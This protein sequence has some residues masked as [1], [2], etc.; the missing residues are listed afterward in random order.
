VLTKELSEL[1]VPRNMTESFMGLAN[2]ICNFSDEIAKYMCPLKL[3][4]K[5]RIKFDWLPKHQAVF[6]G[7]W[8]FLSSQKCWPSTIQ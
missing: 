4:L 7:A 1:P 8:S 2:Q 5:K 6:E 3:L